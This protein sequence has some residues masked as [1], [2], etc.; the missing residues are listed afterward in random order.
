MA[1]RV[2][3]TR[4]PDVVAASYFRSIDK[5]VQEAG[6]A[7]LSLYDTAVKSEMQK[8]GR[9]YVQDG[10]FDFLKKLTSHI[11]KAVSIVYSQQRVNKAASSF[12]KN[13]NQVNKTNMEQQGRVRGI[14]LTVTESWLAPFMK[15][16]I[17]KNVDYITNIRDEYTQKIESIILNGLRDGSSYKSIR[18]QLEEQIGMS[19]NRA[20]FIAV[21]QSGTLF[22]QMTAQRHQNMGVMKFK[23]R[24][25]KDER[26]RDSHK[27]LEDKIF[28]YDD[29]PSVGLPGEDFHCRC[30]ALP[31]FDDEED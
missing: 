21:D 9:G 13:L 1:K 16:N 15:E 27:I 31:I 4:F 17:Q 22:G 19:R 24:T 10:P 12:M 20:K 25:S 29:P 30:I 6:K 11:K 18:E 7:T 14:E 23:W 28:S 5:L 26:V 2:P 8:D 3:P